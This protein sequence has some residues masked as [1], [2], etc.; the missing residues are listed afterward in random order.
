[1]QSLLRPRHVGKTRPSPHDDTLSGSTTDVGRTFLKGSGLLRSR[2]AIGQSPLQFTLAD[3]RRDRQESTIVD[4]GGYRSDTK[5]VW[6]S[7]GVG[8]AVGQR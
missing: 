3:W 2:T 4:Y 7:R 6:D 5:R 8:G 1:M